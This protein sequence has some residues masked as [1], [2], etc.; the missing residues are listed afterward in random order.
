MSHL[1]TMTD[2]MLD[3]INRCPAKLAE[4]CQ[5]IRERAMANQAIAD[6]AELMAATGDAEMLIT[7]LAEL[8]HHRNL[9]MEQR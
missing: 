4:L 7:A 5:T 6:D 9:A 1:D 2:Q 3:A 8:E